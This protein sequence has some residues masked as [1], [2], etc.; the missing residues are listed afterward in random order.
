[1]LYVIE[2]EGRLNEDCTF[3]AGEGNNLVEQIS[4]EGVTVFV[5]EFGHGDVV[6]IVELFVAELFEDKVAFFHISVTVN[7]LF[8]LL[9]K[10]FKSMHVD[11]VLNVLETGPETVEIGAKF[12]EFFLELLRGARLDCDF[13]LYDLGD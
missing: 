3:G 12:G 7:K 9:V 6:V 10:H 1:M 5:L 11:E 2:P 8:E 4:Q 13:F